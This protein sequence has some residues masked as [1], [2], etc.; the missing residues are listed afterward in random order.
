M[1]SESVFRSLSHH[2]KSILLSFLGSCRLRTL[3]ILFSSLDKTAFILF[4]FILFTISGSQY[5]ETN[6]YKQ[7]NSYT[8]TDGQTNR[9]TS[10]TNKL[11]TRK[12]RQPIPGEK[13]RYF[14]M[15]RDFVKIAINLSTR[16]L[17]N[18]GDATPGRTR[19]NDLAERS[20]ALALPCLLLCFA[21]VIV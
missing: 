4:I 21:S 7:L 3:A 10:D 16:L 15:L 9:Q 14:D 12:R 5:R 2:V 6:I 1:T 19:S 8:C 17:K 13:R 20:T 11:V 18:S